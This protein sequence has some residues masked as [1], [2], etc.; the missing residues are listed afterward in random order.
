MTPRGLRRPARHVLSKVVLSIVLAACGGAVG[1]SAAFQETEYKARSIF[2]E[3][4]SVFGLGGPSISSGPTLCQPTNNIALYGSLGVNTDPG[5]GLATFNGIRAYWLAL[6]GANEIDHR[7]PNEG[8]G[9]YSIRVAV[10]GGRSVRGGY[11]LYADFQHQF[12][13]LTVEVTTGC[14]RTAN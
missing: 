9:F 1:G 2:E 6:P 7:E 11:D 8:R 13:A 14:Y 4:L 10:D 5:E 3:T 12:D